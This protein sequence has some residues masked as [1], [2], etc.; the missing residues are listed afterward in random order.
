[1]AIPRGGTLYFPAGIYIVKYTLQLVGDPGHNYTIIGDGGGFTSITTLK[2]AGPAKCTMLDCWGLNWTQFKGLIFDGGGIN[3]HI[4]GSSDP[5]VGTLGAGCAT[6]FH[7]NQY[8][9]VSHPGINATR[10]KLSWKQVGA[11]NLNLFAVTLS[12]E[13]KLTAGHL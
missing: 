2:W 12:P 10:R 4:G 6:W 13:T 5:S 8:G 11:S 1:M 7:T 9:T 3:K